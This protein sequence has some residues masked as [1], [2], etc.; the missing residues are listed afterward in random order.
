MRQT[1][2]AVTF[3]LVLVLLSFLLPALEATAQQSG[4][5]LLWDLYSFYPR[6]IRLEH[7]GTA[8]GTVLVSVVTNLNGNWVGAILQSTD[9]GQTY[10]HIGSVNDPA[11]ASGMCCHTLYELP[12]AVGTL[13][14]GTLLWAA[15]FGADAGQNRRMTE[16]VWKSADRGRTWT[17][18]STIHTAASSAGTWEPEFTV[19]SDGRL[20]AFFSDETDPLHSQKL[21]KARSTDGVTWTDLTP[22]VASPRQQDRPGMAVVRKVPDGRYLMSYELCSSDGA[23][24]CEVY[25]RHSLDGWNWGDPANL[26]LRVRTA[27]GKYPASTPTIVV[28]GNT[29][30]LNAMRLRNADG[31][32]AVGDGRTFLANSTNGDGTWFEIAG[33]I[34]VTNPGGGDLNGVPCTGYSNPLL[35]TADGKAVLVVATAPNSAGHCRAYVGASTL[36]P[37]DSGTSAEASP[38][39]LFGTERHYFARSPSASLRHWWWMGGSIGRDSW[40]EGIAGPPVAFVYGTQQ[41]AFARTSTGTLAHSFWDSK[42]GIRR[43]DTWATGL[44]SA[45]AAMVIGDAQHVW[46]VDTAGNLQQWWWNPTQGTQRNTWASGVAG[47]P[48]VMRVNNVQ[49]VFTRTVSGSIHHGWWSWQQGMRQETFGAGFVGDPVVTQVGDAQHIWGVDG[50]GNLRHWW[51]N[52]NQGWQNDVWGSGVAGRPSVLLVG[53][54]QHVF[55]RSTTGGIKHWWWTPAQGLQ[56]NLWGSGVSLSSDPTAHLLGSEQ[57]VFATDSTGALQHWWTSTTGLRQESWGL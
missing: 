5:R 3:P 48:S 46:A 49:H 7:N 36:A 12:R 41:H 55:A 26:G 29:V 30:L 43:S 28:S 57:H 24:H 47:R 35:P 51:W 27:N 20:V 22:V 8:N 53:D 54:A 45:P 50:S 1:R 52:P 13:P 14:A 32:F 4:G 9:Y 11:A 56:Q 2:P 31:T 39:L 21:V 23:H 42:D 40:G 10:T 38:F 15:S 44:A 33:P 16:R 18:L 25:V 37:I 34:S 19:S 6:V 17:F